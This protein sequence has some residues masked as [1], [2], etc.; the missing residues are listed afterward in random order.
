VVHDP[1]ADEV[2][3]TWSP[4]STQLAFRSD[5]VTK[6]FKGSTNRIWVSDADGRHQRLLLTRGTV[7]K[8]T[9]AAWSR[10]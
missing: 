4:D 2:A 9:L 10:S 5:R 3:I 6:I 1:K 7:G 8:Q